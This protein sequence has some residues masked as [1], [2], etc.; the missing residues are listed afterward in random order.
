M[1]N[2]EGS[3]P[4]P[5]KNSSH[6]ETG[7]EPVT[8]PDSGCDPELDKLSQESRA[9]SVS[10]VAKVDS[11]SKP[12]CQISSDHSD[13]NQQLEGPK[14]SS[15]A[16]THQWDGSP[17][18]EPSSMTGHDPIVLTISTR[19]AKIHNPKDTCS[20]VDLAHGSKKKFS[21]SESGHETLVA[22]SLKKKKKKHK[23]KSAGRS[24]APR[25]ISFSM[26]QPPSSIVKDYSWMLTDATGGTIP[27][28][29]N[30][31]VIAVD[32][33]QEDDGVS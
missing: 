28:Q 12:H 2:Q 27:D 8:I 4:P 6:K 11:H 3:S 33:P 13:D 31:K 16:K 18:Y 5:P 19:S 1:G 24:L 9:A 22:D 23:T 10:A 30:P 20:Q 14:H 32:E 25:F 26:H 7:E 29:S 15:A 17:D 21:S